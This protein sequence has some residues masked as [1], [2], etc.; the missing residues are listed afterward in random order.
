VLRAELPRVWRFAVTP[1]N[2]D[3]VALIAPEVWVSDEFYY[4]RLTNGECR[5]VEG[6]EKARRSIEQEARGHQ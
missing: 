4:D 6:F 1:N 3:H 2:A 5:A